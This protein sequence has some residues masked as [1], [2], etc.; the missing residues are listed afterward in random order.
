MKLGCARVSTKDQD[1]ALQADALTQAGCEEIYN[2]KLSGATKARPQLQALLGQLRSGDV[3]VI[4]KLD[5]LG[6]SLKN[7][8]ALV[9]EIE[10]KGAELLCTH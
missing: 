8:V 7:L 5:R 2:D 3:V 6:R 10:S 4:W 1:L 9:N